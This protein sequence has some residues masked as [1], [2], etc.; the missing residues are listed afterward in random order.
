MSRGDHVFF[1]TSP[2]LLRAFI[3]LILAAGFGIRLYD[4]TD[5]PLDFHETRQLG[6]AI[7]ARGMYYQMAPDAPAE[8]KAKAIELWHDAP[9]YEPQF[10]ERLVALTY[11]LIGGE[12]LWV[13]R[14]YTALFWILG[15]VALYQLAK[16]LTSEDGGVLALIFYMFLPYGVIASRSFQPDPLMVALTVFA[17]LAQYRWGKKPTWSRA[18]LAGL[19]GGTAVLV[20]AVAVFPVV[21]GLL[22]IAL[23]TLGLRGALLRGQVWVLGALSLLPAGLYNLF[24]IPER[25]GGLFSFWVLSFQ[26]L[27]VTPSFYVRWVERAQSVATFGALVAAMFGVLL[28]SRGRARSIMLGAW[29][30]Y[31]VYGLMLPYQIM[32]HDYYHLIL[33]P[34]VSVS[35][36]PWFSLGFNRLAGESRFWRAAAMIVLVAAVGTQIWHV[37]VTLARKDYRLEAAGWRRFQELLPQDGD[38]VALTHGYGFRLAYYAWMDVRVWPYQADRRVWQLA[39]RPAKPFE[40]EFKERTQGADYFLITHFGEYEA[41][42]ELKKY[43]EA[44]YCVYTQ[45]DGYL[46]FD[47]SQRCP[48]D[49]RPGQD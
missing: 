42:A 27:L 33:I 9:V 16:R 32:T 24:F 47:L 39:G 35:L 28:L 10:L 15:G 18:I 29:A 25:S 4:L 12:Y 1:G 30:G 19:L 34:L 14:I 8:L 2:A 49:T 43:L 45:G 46:V 17:W 3:I 37:R 7:I 13:S 38:V 11:V 21:G 40:E 31:L 26:E 22:G 6:S 5:A 23:G 41:Q 36:A 48:R 44:N 20:K